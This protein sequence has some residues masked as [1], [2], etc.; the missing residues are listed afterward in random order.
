[1]LM[2]FVLGWNKHF[3]LVD[4]ILKNQYVYTYM[5]KSEAK[6]DYRIEGYLL[7]VVFVVKLLR[8]MVKS[9]KILKNIKK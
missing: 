2:L 5:N 7:L 8:F 3:S 1:M 4:T 9:Y 6:V